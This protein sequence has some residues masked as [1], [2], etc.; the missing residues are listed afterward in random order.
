MT[1]YLLAIKQFFVDPRL[2]KVTFFCISLSLLLF[3]VL[4][5]GVGWTLQH[6]AEK[7]A[8]AARVLSWGSWVGAFVVTLFLFPTLF[9]FIGSFFYESIADAVDAKYYAHLPKADGPAL[10]ASVASGLRYF[11]LMLVLNSF[12]LPVYLVLIFALGSGFGLYVLVN[13]ILLGREHYDAVA[14]RRRA[15]GAAA[16][17][18]KRNRGKLLLNGVL[19]AAVGLI[20]FVNLMAALFGVASM[21]HLVNQGL[22]NAKT[23]PHA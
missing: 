5:G 11:L 3:A 6:F 22:A 20:P 8:W 15:E 21:T 1:A 10:S 4:M 2:W 17:W 16:E 14:L 7:S 18:R 13:G 23:H 9:G 12:A 19:T